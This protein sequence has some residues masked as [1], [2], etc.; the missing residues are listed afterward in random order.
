MSKI[1]REDI[2]GTVTPEKSVD[3]LLH[4]LGAYHDL[5]AID[6]YLELLWSEAAQPFERSRLGQ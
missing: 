1:K 3:I 2:A 4:L 5:G 6:K